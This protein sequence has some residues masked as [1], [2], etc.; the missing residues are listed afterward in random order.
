MSVSFDPPGKGL[1]DSIASLPTDSTPPN[2]SEV[3]VLDTLFKRD[4]ST[5]QKFLDGT[6]DIILAGL[7]F[8]LFSIPQVNSLIYK[9]FPSSTKS[10]YILLFIR[11]CIFMLLFFVLKNFYLVRNKA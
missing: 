7:L 5:V 1:G 11:V 4:K 8:A 2:P 3:Q 10:E 9:L 6:K